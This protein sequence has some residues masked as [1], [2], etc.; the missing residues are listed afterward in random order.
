MEHKGQKEFLLAM[1]GSRPDVKIEF[2]DK[3][4]ANGQKL[5]H[6]KV[7]QLYAVEPISMYFL[8]E[9]WERFSTLVHDI[10]LMDEVE[11]GAA[12]SQ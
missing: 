4:T 7:T 9:E 10:R 1:P 6:V 8:P 11:S 2:L 5:S 3:S 12:S